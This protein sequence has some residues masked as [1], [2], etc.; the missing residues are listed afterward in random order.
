ITDDGPTDMLLPGLEI[1][2]AYRCGLVT[3]NARNTASE[4]L[5]GIYIS[6]GLDQRGAL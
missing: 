5:H 2:A 1:T 6:E 3:G 4:G